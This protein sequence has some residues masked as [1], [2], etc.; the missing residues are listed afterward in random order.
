VHGSRLVL[1][2]RRQTSKPEQIMIQDV[3]TGL[4]TTTSRLNCTRMWLHQVKGKRGAR[5]SVSGKYVQSTSGTYWALCIQTGT[6]SHPW[7]PS[8][9]P[10]PICLTPLVPSFQFD[11]VAI[12][13]K[14]E[15]G[16]CSTSR[17]HF[18]LVRLIQATLLVPATPTGERVSRSLRFSASVKLMTYKTT[19]HTPV[20]HL[21]FVPN[22]HLLKPPV[23]VVPD[24]SVHR[25]SRRTDNL[26]T[27]Q[28]ASLLIHTS[29]ADH[30]ISCRYRNKPEGRG[31]IPDGILEILVDL[32]LLAALR[33]WG[34]L[35]I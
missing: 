16:S 23:A 2:K 22:P 12:T 17:C 10:L 26:P 11:T 31:S 9:S 34:R 3:L 25:H 21:V 24:P 15:E 32:I 7:L 14:Q 13:F 28:Q 5:S 18:V 4:L 27:L 1:W 35:S 8:P 20:V 6:E 19:R 29:S 33:P 30:G